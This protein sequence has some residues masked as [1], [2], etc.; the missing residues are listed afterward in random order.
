MEGFRGRHTG[1]GGVVV[2]AA[3][4][5]FRKACEEVRVRLLRGLIDRKQAR[6]MYRRA[7]EAYN[8]AVRDG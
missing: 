3:R 2:N 8:A 6:A 4:L 1:L 7:T 5:A